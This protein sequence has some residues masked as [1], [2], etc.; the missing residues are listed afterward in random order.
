MTHF[1]GKIS[2]FRSPFSYLGAEPEPLNPALSL[3]P[4]GCDCHQHCRDIADHRRHLLRG[5]PWICEAESL[6]F[7]DRNRPAGG[8]SY[9][10]GNGGFYQQLF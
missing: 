2:E 5:G 9:F 4:A 8:D 6:Q 1:F 7:Q 10:S 3:L